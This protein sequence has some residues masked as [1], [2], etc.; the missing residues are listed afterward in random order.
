MSRYKVRIEVTG[1]NFDGSKIDS[2][3]EFEAENFTMDES[4]HWPRPKK[5]EGEH[6]P[7]NKCVATIRMVGPAVTRKVGDL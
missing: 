2:F 3:V 5:G 7:M 4:H 6:P 1:A